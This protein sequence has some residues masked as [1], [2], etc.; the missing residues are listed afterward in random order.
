MD[1]GYGSEAFN[2]SILVG[3]AGVLFSPGRS[4]FLYSPILVMAVLGARWM[5]AADKRRALII[6]GAA[7][8]YILAVAAWQIWW[9]GKAWGSRLL[10]PVVPLLG[11]LM[12]A[13]VD[14]ALRTQARGLM[15]AIAILGMAGLGVQLLTLTANPV[16]VL[17]SYLAS[18][19]ATYAE[20]ILSP[21]KN[22]LAL[23]L[24]NLPNATPCTID[25]YSLRTLFAQCR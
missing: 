4:L 20:S 2:G 13:T 15:S 6:M 9:G 19:Y 21:S 24:R 17:D 23:Q 14:R 22:W 11:T 7:G 5:F 10:T 16:V 8:S 18:G 25:A 12:A 3:L 1:F